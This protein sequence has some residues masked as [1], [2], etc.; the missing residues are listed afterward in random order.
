MKS[1]RVVIYTAFY[2]PHLGGVEFYARETAV[3]LAEL[4]FEV[5]VITSDVERL[6]FEMEDNGVKVFRLPVFKILGGRMPWPKPGKELNIVLKYLREFDPDFHIANMRF[7]AHTLLAARLTE[8]IGGRLIVIEHNTGRF[9]LGSPIADF[10]AKVYENLATNFVKKRA[11]RFYGVSRACL[12]WL[13]TFGVRGSGVLYNGIDPEIASRS[14]GYEDDL[15]KSGDKIFFVAGGRIIREKGFRLLCRAFVRISEKYPQAALRI[16]GDGPDLHYLK[17][18]FSDSGIEFLGERHR[19]FVLELLKKSDLI[20]L[21]SYYPEGLSTMLLEGGACGCAAISTDSGGAKELIK[22]DRF[23]L[24]VPKRSEA[25]LE[26]AMSKMIEKEDYRTE[27]AKNLHERI[28]EKFDRK[29]IARS[30]AEDLSE[31]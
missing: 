2:P 26:A 23:G 27:S 17:E 20:V 6:G 10:A 30:F 5:V 31:L 9:R 13:K 11:F 8:T 1:K 14:T 7:Y 28:V 25:D 29:K 22:S 4:G 21:P 3:N 24:I 18:K 19:D 15:E 12:D 16:V